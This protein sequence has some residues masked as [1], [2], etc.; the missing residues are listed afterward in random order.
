ML[1]ILLLDEDVSAVRAYK[2]TDFEVGF[3]LIES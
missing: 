1:A 2:S 3:I